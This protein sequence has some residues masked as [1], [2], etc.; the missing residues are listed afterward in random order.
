[1]RCCYLVYLCANKYGVEDPTITNLVYFLS[2]KKSIQE[3][4]RLDYLY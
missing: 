4:G 2:S 1:M 3:N